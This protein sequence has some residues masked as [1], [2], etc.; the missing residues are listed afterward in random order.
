MAKAA[1]PVNLSG[2]SAVSQQRQQVGIG[3]KEALVV[4]FLSA[5]CPCSDSHIPELR[6]LQKEYPQFQF[7]GVHSNE[8]ENVQDTQTYFKDAKLPFTVLRDKKFKIADTFGALKTPHAFVISRQGEV[9]YRGGVSSSH[10]FAD[11]EHKYLRAALQDIARKQTV[12]IPEGRVLG[13]V[14]SRGGGV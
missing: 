8:E 1:L 11:A 10:E 13:C 4:V 3:D 14:I 12:R 2:F 5:V 9:L 6:N 7:V